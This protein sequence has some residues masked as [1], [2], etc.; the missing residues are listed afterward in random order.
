MRTTDL[1]GREVHNR[2][3]HGLA[4]RGCRKRSR[5]ERRHRLLD[6]FIPTDTRAIASSSASTSFNAAF[7]AAEPSGRHGRRYETIPLSGS[8]P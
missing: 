1:A 5:S 8:I 7:D 6:Y 3:G 4:V 2:G